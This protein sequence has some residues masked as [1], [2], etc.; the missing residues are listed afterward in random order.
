MAPPAF[1]DKLCPRAELAARMEALPRRVVLALVLLALGIY[2]SLL[3]QSPASPYFEQTL[4]DWEQGRFIRFHG[5]AQ[6]LGWLW[7]YAALV[8]LLIL[9]GDA[10]PKKLESAT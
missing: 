4:S 8:Y 7:P 6:W 5:L 1:L 9:V 2:L 3:N 10:A